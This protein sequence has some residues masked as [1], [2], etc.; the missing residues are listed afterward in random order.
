M[1]KPSRR[2]FI[3]TS[4]KAALATGLGIFAL[5]NVSAMSAKSMFIHH[6]YFWLKN[7]SSKEDLQKLTEGLQKLSKVKTIKMFHIGKPADT[8]REVIDASYAISWLNVFDSK[9]DQDSYQEDPIH[10]KF[11]EECSPLWSK[12]IVY[13]SVD[14]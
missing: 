13:D 2:T 11:V 7:P 12:V 8:N 6:V 9:A 1:S 14:L 5:N 3:S 4:G 10:L